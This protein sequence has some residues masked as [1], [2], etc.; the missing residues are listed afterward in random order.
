MDD[1]AAIICAIRQQVPKLAKLAER[2]CAYIPGRKLC[3]ITLE[4]LHGYAQYRDLSRADASPADQLDAACAAGLEPFNAALNG[5]R[6]AQ[7]SGDDVEMPDWLPQLRCLVQA[8][9]PRVTMLTELLLQQRAPS[10]PAVR[11]L[12]CRGWCMLPDHTIVP[13]PSSLSG[14]AAAPGQVVAG[15]PVP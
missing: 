6:A 1:L 10:C 14:A 8:G 13:D 2:C 12:V 4:A 7:A 3:S 11:D 9:V 15:V 5:W